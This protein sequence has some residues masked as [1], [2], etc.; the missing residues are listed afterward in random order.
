[1]SSKVVV[2]LGLSLVVFVMI[3]S[4][5]TARE[6]AETTTTSFNPEAG[7]TSNLQ[8]KLRKQMGLLEMTSTMAVEGGANTV[9]AAMATTAAVVCAAHTR[10]RPWRMQPSLKQSLIANAPKQAPKAGLK[11][12]LKATRPSSA[13]GP[14]QPRSSSVLD[15]K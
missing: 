14:K 6:M 5:V 4:E 12:G 9:V 1:M 15:L 7:T 3:A 13:F 2:L 8:Q 11:A 10:G